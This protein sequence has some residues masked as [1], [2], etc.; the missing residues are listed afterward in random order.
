MRWLLLL[1]AALAWEERG[2]EGAPTGRSVGAAQHFAPEAPDWSR[3][4]VSTS[5]LDLAHVARGTLEVLA[6]LREGDS[7]LATAGLFSELGVSLDDVVDTLELV[8][9]V[10]EEDRGR[11]HQ[12][13]QDP[14]WIAANFEVLRWR[15]DRASA[16]RR[17]IDLDDGRIRLTKYVVYSV[18]GSPV[19]TER[20]DTALYAAPADDGLRARLTRMDVYAGA[21]DDGGEAAGQAIP[22]IWLT[23]HGS[24]Q[25]LMQ[26]TIEV[27]VPDGSVR[28]YNVH[29]NNG[30]PWDPAIKDPNRQARYWYFREVEGVLGVEQIPLRPRVAVAGDVYNLGLGKLIALEWPTER[31]LELRLAVLADTGGAFQPNLFQLDYL[32]GTFPSEAEYRAWARHT[33]TR[34]P[35]AVL[36][37]RR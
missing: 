16:R 22:L 8:V 20:Y 9:R 7:P 31:G 2:P 15:P 21:F 4:R 37:R 35:A 28:L 13:L 25:A 11:E 1:S 24:N 3:A 34:V 29:Q 18:Q 17:K 14:R 33:P 26:G 10:A 27:S 36:V 5:P 30:V 12:R 6:A 19:R 32:A 23:R